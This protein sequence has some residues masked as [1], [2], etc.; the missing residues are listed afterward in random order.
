MVKNTVKRTVGF[1]FPEKDV[2]LLKRVSKARG[3]DVSDFVRRCVR[4][5]LARLSF[6]SDM[7]KKALGIVEKKENNIEEK[8]D[9]IS[10]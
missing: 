1:R 5:E 4:M 2:R 10:M 9:A 3:E 8:D 6:F 7:E